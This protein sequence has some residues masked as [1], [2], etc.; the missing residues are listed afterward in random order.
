MPRELKSNQ[1]NVSFILSKEDHK[2]ISHKAQ[3]LGMSLAAYF[4]FCALNSDI[5]AQIKEPSK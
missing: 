3:S 1:I 4:K 5:K 2:I